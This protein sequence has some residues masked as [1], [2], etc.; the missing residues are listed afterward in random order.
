MNKRD[1]LKR[2]LSAV[3]T[4]SGLVLPSGCEEFAAEENFYEINVA[5]E[6][7]REI[8]ALDLQRAKERE[9]SQVDANEAPTAEL[10]LSLEQCR[11]LTLA[12]NLDLKVQLVSPAIAA[13]RVSEEEARFEAAFSSNVSYTKTDTPVSTKLA[14]SRADISQIDLG[15]QVPLRTGGMVTF[16]LADRRIKT[17]ETFSEFSEALN[18]EYS[19]NFSISISHELLRG[20]GKRANTHAIRIAEYGRQIS[21]ARTKLEVIRVL[22]LADTMYWRLYA[23]KR[24]LDV[25]KQQYELAEA[26]LGKAQR[27]VGSGEMAQVEIIRAEAGVAERLEGIIVAEN[28]LRDRQRELKRILNKRG[29]EMQTPTV[30]IPATSPDPVHYELNDEQLVTIA[31]EG[32]MEMLDLELQIAQDIS[33]IDFQRNQY[34]PLVTL[35]YRYNINGLGPVRSDAYDLL[36]DKR[37]EDHQ[38]G[39]RLLVPLGNAAG[40][41]RLMQAFYQRRQRLATRQTRQTLI[42]LEVLKAADQLEANW[43]RILAS[44]QNAILAGRLFEAEKRQFELGLRTSTDVL[45]AQT[46]F[47][48]AQRGEILALAEYQIALV[49]LSVATGTLLG[50]AKVQWEPTVPEKKIQ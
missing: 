7:L 44:R 20:A 35:D 13:Q 2:F 17:D 47:A 34:L 33:T 11:A 39:L 3:V 15:V 18:P 14:G 12:N 49:D 48:D 6:R 38:I 10:E 26:Q 4:I 27:L 28:S 9:K 40:R 45:D 32:R 8:D 41:S 23:A 43:Q 21:E 37:F 36:Y 42:E 22:A 30:L 29:V 5:P 19:S 31:V 1:F 24:E 50:A 16:N 46:K 25:R